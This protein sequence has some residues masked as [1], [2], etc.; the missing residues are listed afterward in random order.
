MR[1]EFSNTSG[2]RI[3]LD[4]LYVTGTY[5][6]IGEGTP[7]VQSNDCLIRGAAK[8][9][10]RF[11]GSRATYVVPP[12][13]RIVE[14]GGVRYEKMPPTVFYAWLSSTPINPKWCGSELV[15]V[16]F[17]DEPTRDPLPKLLTKV[18]AELQWE[19]LAKDYD[20]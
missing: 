2:R 9:M 4:A 12:E 6:G 1:L 8:A 11:W 20:E 14:E 10:E 7:S 18:A 17:D 19:Q 3:W 16:W 13:R 5:A 15:V